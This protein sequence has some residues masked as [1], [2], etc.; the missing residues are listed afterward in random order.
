MSG[1]QIIQVLSVLNS[2]IDA[3]LN[4]NLL[5]I[6][7]IQIPAIRLQG[8]IMRC[9]SRK[10][11]RKNAEILPEYPSLPIS[12]RSQWGFWYWEFLALLDCNKVGPTSIASKAAWCSADDW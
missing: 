1:P 5:S 12:V 10:K 11:R 7:G 8:I 9:D 6:W 2:Q 4:F 3:V